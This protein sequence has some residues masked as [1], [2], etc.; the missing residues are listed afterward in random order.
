[1]RTNKL[2]MA[3]C[4]VVGSFFLYCGQSA[5]NGVTGNNRDGGPIGDASA[6]SSGGG[7]MCCTPP[8]QTF[9]KLASGDFSTTPN[10]PPIP[11][12]GFRELVFYG[13]MNCIDTA[14]RADASSPFVSAG[15]NFSANTINRLTVQGSDVQLSRV[16]GSGCITGAQPWVLAG[17]GN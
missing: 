9:T 12:A 16:S 15:Q 1:M 2:A 7:G 10:P 3:L 11:T 13:Q 17:V 4:I 6:Q 8:P 14:Y 5:M